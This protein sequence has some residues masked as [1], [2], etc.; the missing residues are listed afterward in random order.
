MSVQKFGLGTPVGTLHGAGSTQM[1]GFWGESLHGLPWAVCCGVVSTAVP[2]NAFQ[3]EQ[4]AVKQ[5]R[6]G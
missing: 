6:G 2:C 4:P 3:E 5:S 1:S